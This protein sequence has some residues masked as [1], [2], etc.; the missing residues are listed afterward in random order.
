MYNLNRHHNYSRLN[1]LTPV[2]YNF[3]IKSTSY[4]LQQTS[5]NLSNRESYIERYGG[6]FY[7]YKKNHYSYIPSS[8]KFSPVKIDPIDF[9]WRIYNQKHTNQIFQSPKREINIIKK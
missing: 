6:Y 2:H 1:N 4:N 5:L 8:P 9:K 7:I 3:K